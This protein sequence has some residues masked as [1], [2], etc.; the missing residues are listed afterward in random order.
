MG[1]LNTN[2]A[3]IEAPIVKVATMDTDAHGGVFS[4]LK[5][6][7]SFAAYSDREAFDAWEKQSLQTY[8]EGLAKIRAKNDGKIHATEKTA[9]ERL[10]DILL[11]A[12][13]EDKNKVVAA[14]EEDEDKVVA[15]NEKDA[16]L[17]SAAAFMY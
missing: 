12:D 11:A 4:D 10:E 7:H 6:D 2:R 1:E 3:V 16:K 14:D 13:E 9:T 15:A 17:L 8:K 5:S